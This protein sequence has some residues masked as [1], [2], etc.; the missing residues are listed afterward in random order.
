M[1]IIDNLKQEMISY[2]SGDPQRIQHFIKVHAFAAFIAKKEQLAEE[3]RVVCE[4]AALV[5]DIGIKAAE[6]TYGHNTGKLQEKLGPELAYRL[7]QAV[8]EKQKS[9]YKLTDQQI[10]RIC[11]LVGHHHTYTGVDGLDYRILVES[12]FLVNMYEDHYP[13]DAIKRA[14]SL[15]FRTRTGRM[16][17]RTIYGLS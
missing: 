14:Y 9:L 16:I 3:Q 13:M 7:V 15:F 17:C 10:D 8:N 4:C 6:T 5:H 2:F 11:Y 12:D 1:N